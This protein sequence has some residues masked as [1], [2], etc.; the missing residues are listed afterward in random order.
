MVKSG[1][2]TIILLFVWALCSPVMA[3]SVEEQ[4]STKKEGNWLLAKYDLN[5]DAQITLNEVASK[6]R[7]IFKYMDTDDD[8]TVSFEEYETMDIVKR[9]A[10][11]KA[12]FN[13]LDLDHDGTLTE[14]EYCNYLGLFKSI[15]SDG[16]GTLTSAEMVT[17]QEK[18]QKTHCL[19]WFCVRTELD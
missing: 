18:V 3:E 7:N 8:G 4:N 11:L 17:E 16:N 14:K 5:G 19:L 2:T 1:I 13:K 15:D 9:D 10:L 6:K 12:R